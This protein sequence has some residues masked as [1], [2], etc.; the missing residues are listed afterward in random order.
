MVTSSTTTKS[1]PSVSPS[2]AGASAAAASREID[3]VDVDDCDPTTEAL[4]GALP[5]EKPRRFIL[6]DDT[7]RGSRVRVKV[8]LDQVSMTEIPDSYRL[9]NAVYPRAYFP[10]Q[11]RDSPAGGGGG[12]RRGV[13]GRRYVRTTNESEIVAHDDDGGDAAT[14]GRT[15]VPAPS[16][17][18]E[19][20]IIAVPRISRSRHRKEVVLNNLGYRMSWSQ[21]RVFAGRQTFLQK[22]RMSPSLIFL[23]S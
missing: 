12:D 14:V 21:S 13:S 6:V 7:Q 9:S 11:M 17:D 20:E 8:S 23:T 2:T 5:K 15:M 10:M 16:A 19:S 3:P 18:G 4:F 1:G 22:S